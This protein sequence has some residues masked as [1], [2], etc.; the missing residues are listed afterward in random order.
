MSNRTK[1]SVC[2]FVACV[3]VDRPMPQATPHHPASRGALHR[4]H[5]GTLGSEPRERWLKVMKAAYANLIAWHNTKGRPQLGRPFSCAWER[6]RGESNAR[7]PDPQSGALSTKLRAPVVRARTDSTH[8]TR[9]S[10]ECKI[11]ASPS[12]VASSPGGPAPRDGI[13]HARDLDHGLDVMDAHDVGAACDA[14]GHG[15][16][17]AFQALLRGRV[18]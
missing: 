6:A 5:D 17:R 3:A 9:C 15:G 12:L 18:A 14:N 10:G 7:P 1:R 8:Y 2:S 4:R 16:G 11:H 13:R